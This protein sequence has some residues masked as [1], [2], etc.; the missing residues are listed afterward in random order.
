MI[1]EDEGGLATD[2]EYNQVFIALDAKND[3][4]G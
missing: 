2:V 3:S 4:I 1:E